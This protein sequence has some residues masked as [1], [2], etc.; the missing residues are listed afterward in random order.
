[1]STGTATIEGLFVHQDA[2]DRHIA[3]PMLRERVAYLSQLMTAGHD[4]SFVAARASTLL[5]VTRLMHS[6]AGSVNEEAIARGAALWIAEA[7]R[8]T[9]SYPCGSKDFV[10]ASRS[11]FRFLGVYVS[12]DMSSSCFDSALVKFSKAMQS[13]FGYLPSTITSC[14]RRSPAWAPSA[15]PTS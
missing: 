13:D 14:K 3:A 11:W 7:R 5:N 2:I 15:S 6:I 9:P 4:R 12:P 10:A 1:M 8:P